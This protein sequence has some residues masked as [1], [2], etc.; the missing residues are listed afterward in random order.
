[1]QD[2]RLGDF[3]EF[4]TRDGFLRRDLFFTQN[5]GQVP[6]DGFAFSVR[7]SRQQDVIGFFGCAHNRID[8]LFIA[9]DELVL[10]GEIVLGID[11][12]GF[13]HQ[14]AHVSIA[15]EDFV[16]RAEVFFEG[17]CLGRRLD[18]DEKRHTLNAPR[19]L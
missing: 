15:G 18:Y 16:L 9:L 17:F 10:H 5:F 3:V 2:R 1:M 14:I 19:G 4:D 6:C 8:V 12:T 11:R 13:R 7:V